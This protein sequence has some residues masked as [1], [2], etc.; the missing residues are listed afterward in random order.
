MKKI[1][2]I[3]KVTSTLLIGFLILGFQ[4]QLR[5][6]ADVATLMKA[7]VADA[8]E[9]ID[10]YISPF[11]KAFGTSMNGGWF[12]TARYMKP[13]GVDL[14][15]SVNSVMVPSSEQSFDFDDLDAS[16]FELIN[17]GSK[18]ESP[19]IFGENKDGPE[20]GVLKLPANLGY[21]D[22]FSL[23]PGLG[24]TFLPMPSAQ[25]RIGTFK[26]TDLIIRFMPEISVP[27][28]DISGKIKFWGL[29][30]KH[31]IKQWITGIKDKPFDLAF[32]VS[33]SKFSFDLDFP[34]QLT[35]EPGSVYANNQPISDTSI[36]SDQGLS[37]DAGSW[38]LNAI[39][40]RQYSVI[41]LYG[42]LGVN[43]SKSEMKLKGKYPVPASY[44]QNTGN[45]IVQ[46]IDDPIDVS[47]SLT[48]PK[49]TAGFRLKLAF[50][51][52][53]ADYTYTKYPYIS[54]GIGFVFAESKMKKAESKI[55]EIEESTT[56]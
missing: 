4:T 33:Y 20:I 5:A 35:P 11:G 3:K 51:T 31:D 12:N 27:G 43:G 9:L 19:T 15:I 50:F 30:A 49:I 6:Q 42:A 54:A 55:E 10:A 29:G 39:F 40:S 26:N 37:Y 7:G 32:L 53:H 45:L 41:T 52:I 48:N 44:D 13:G 16:T 34:Y 56:D 23:P 36:F 38:S 28:E 47:S 24:F 17:A 21:G 8:N 2:F 22:T 46:N 14:N 1:N 25:L 18:T